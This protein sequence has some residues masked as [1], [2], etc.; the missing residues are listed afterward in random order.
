MPAY[1]V[2]YRLHRETGDMTPREV[3]E[4]EPRVERVVASDAQRAIS[5]LVNDLKGDGIINSKADVKFL[6]VRMIP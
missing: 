1:S 5:S 2:S 6:E 3:I 4:L